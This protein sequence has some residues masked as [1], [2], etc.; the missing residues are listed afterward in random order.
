M[1]IGKQDLRRHFSRMLLSAINANSCRTIAT[2][3]NTFMK[4]ACKFHLEY[5]LADEPG[6]EMVADGPHMTS[7]FIL[8]LGVMFPDM[9]L[10]EKSCQL[11]TSN[12][13]NGTKLVINCSFASTAI[14]HISLLRAVAQMH[15]LYAHYASQI[16]SL[17]NS[18]SF[19]N[20]ESG[21]RSPGSSTSDTESQ[22]G[23]GRSWKTEEEPTEPDTGEDCHLTTQVRDMFNH[24]PLLRTPRDISLS[25]T[26][27]IILDH[28]NKMEQVYVNLSD[29]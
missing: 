1:R 25:C 17:C 24:V 7:F 4:Q 28:A 26:I 11:F 18:Q 16:P 22:F 15:G 21:T 6:F 13:W 2:F 8:G 19:D 23:S 12:L 29:L 20:S 27:T 10:L 3:F 5:P 14:Y 9:I